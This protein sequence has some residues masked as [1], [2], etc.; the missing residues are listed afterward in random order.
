MEAVRQMIGDSDS[1]TSNGWRST[2]IGAA[3]KHQRYEAHLGLVERH[4]VGESSVT[5]LEAV[6]LQYA[7]Q[8]IIT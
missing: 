5:R 7:L 3:P 8:I 1:T 6:E 4:L 2:S